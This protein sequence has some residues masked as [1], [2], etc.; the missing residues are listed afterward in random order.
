MTIIAS[1]GDSL[2]FLAWNTV[3]NSGM[4]GLSIVSW[5]GDLQMVGLHS[6]VPLVVSVWGCV[7]FGAL[8]AQ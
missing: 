5:T 4:K 6:T 7:L 3:K 2:I 8:Y 1:F